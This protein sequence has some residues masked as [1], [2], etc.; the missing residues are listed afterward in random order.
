MGR[1]ITAGSIH[2]YVGS[3]A[4]LGKVQGEKW[5]GV[6]NLDG[7]SNATDLTNKTTSL[8]WHKEA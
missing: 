2:C 6:T 8:S 5:W 3:E 7:F 4:L 1:C